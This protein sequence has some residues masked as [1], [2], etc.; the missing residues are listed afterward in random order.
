M[1]LQIAA[2][3]T[4][5]LFFALYVAKTKPFFE[6]RDNYINLLNEW[7]YYMVSVCYFCFT[8]FNPNPEVKVYCGWYIVVVAIS[9][10]LCPNC[11]VMVQKL[12]PEIKESWAKK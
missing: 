11:Y 8:D 7:C 12:W 1:L 4:L 3:A 9:N 2:N 6:M 5:S 10:L